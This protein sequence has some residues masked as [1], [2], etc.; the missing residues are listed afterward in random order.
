[1]TVEDRWNSLRIASKRVLQAFRDGG[2]PTFEQLDKLESA[3]EAVE[4]QRICGHR[5][6]DGECDCGEERS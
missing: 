3:I 5:Y 4:F 1:M 6:V 2:N